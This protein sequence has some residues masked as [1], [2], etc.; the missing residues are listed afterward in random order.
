[1]IIQILRM[2]SFLLEDQYTIYYERTNH[3]KKID[4]KSHSTCI[5]AKM[6]KSEF[7]A[8]RIK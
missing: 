7:K 6:A 1:M 2:P 3:P 4:I 8:K 5:G